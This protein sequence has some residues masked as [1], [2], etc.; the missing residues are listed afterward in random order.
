MIINHIFTYL[1]PSSLD[2]AVTYTLHEREEGDS[3]V[4]SDVRSLPLIF[5]AELFDIMRSSPAPLT[6]VISMSLAAMPQ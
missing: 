5:E 6:W 4:A 2:G 3:R 1:V